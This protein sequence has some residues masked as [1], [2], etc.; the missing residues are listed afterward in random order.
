MVFTDVEEI[1]DPITIEL[2]WGACAPKPIA[3]A[4]IAVVFA[5]FPIAREFE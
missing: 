1:W 3:I 5:M 2:I 4:R